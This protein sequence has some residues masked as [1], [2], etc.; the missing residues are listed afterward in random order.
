MTQLLAMGSAGREA[1]KLIPQDVQV[2]QNYTN[3]EVYYLEHACMTQLLAM[4]SA[5]REAIKLLPQDVQVVQN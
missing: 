2:V 5:G 4:G 1:I 3:N